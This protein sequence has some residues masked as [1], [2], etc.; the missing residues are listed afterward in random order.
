MQR[1]HARGP[2]SSSSSLVLL[3]VLC[4]ARLALPG[5]ARGAPS[6]AHDAGEPQAVA[7]DNVNGLGAGGAGKG[8][9]STSG[10]AGGATS[11]SVAEGAIGPKGDPADKSDGYGEPARK[12]A[13]AEAELARQRRELLKQ[14]Q[15]QRDKEL[16]AVRGAL[17][18]AVAN[19]GGGAKGAANAKAGK[20]SKPVIFSGEM[21]FFRAKEVMNHC[22][23][24][25]GPIKKGGV[26]H[27]WY[28]AMYRF[29]CNAAAERGKRVQV[30]SSSQGKQGWPCARQPRSAALRTVASFRRPCPRSPLSPF[31]RRS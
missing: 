3:L 10:G 30:R 2:F 8:W 22:S 18:E 19:A 11:G 31:T 23:F 16:N 15:E 5:A 27:H 12:L 17:A 4:C 24:Y 21:T 7:P 29:R 26:T 28:A 20:P 6:P 13:E 14:R 9:V 25:Q 1:A